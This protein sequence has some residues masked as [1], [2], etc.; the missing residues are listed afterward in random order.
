[1]TIWI[2]K[3][4]IFIRKIVLNYYIVFFVGGGGGVSYIR[5]IFFN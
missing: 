2:K 5:K 3:G 1:M 4:R